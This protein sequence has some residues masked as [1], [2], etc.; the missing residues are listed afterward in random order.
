[1]P[2][3]TSEALASF[4]TALAARERIGKAD[5]IGSARWMVARTLRSMN[6]HDEALAILRDLE[7]EGQASG[8]ADGYVFEEIGENLLA[9]HDD[10]AARPY[11]AKAWA[12]LDADHSLDRPSEGRLRACSASA[13]RAS[14]RRQSRQSTDRRGKETR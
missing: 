1:M 7:R 8:D 3:A 4:E 6:R 2:A 13:A 5:D 12:L 11:F 10:A 9:Q 14:P